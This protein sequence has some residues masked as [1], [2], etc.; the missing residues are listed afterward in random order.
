MIA[1]PS[2]CY[3]PPPSPMSQGRGG[4]KSSAQQAVLAE[5]VRAALDTHRMH[6]VLPQWLEQC[7][8]LGKRLPESEYLTFPKSSSSTE[9]SNLQPGTSAA[10]IKDP[11]LHPDPV[12]DAEESSGDESSLSSPRSRRRRSTSQSDEDEEELAAD[13]FAFSGSNLAL[14]P[15][16]NDFIT[17]GQSIQVTGN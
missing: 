1:C 17:P 10:I 8:R 15:A 2:T 14:P 9:S 7:Q 12:E 11:H 6:V 4:L 13:Q 16:K 3:L 5:D